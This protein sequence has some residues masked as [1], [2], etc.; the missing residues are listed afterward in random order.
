MSKYDNFDFISGSAK[1]ALPAYL[2]IILHIKNISK[3]TCDWL[4]LSELAKCVFL[5]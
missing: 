5:Y 1:T 3:K 2:Q 4:V